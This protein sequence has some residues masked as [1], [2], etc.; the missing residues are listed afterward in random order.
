VVIPETRDPDQGTGALTAEQATAEGSR[1]A[2]RAL[3]P[4]APEP[5]PRT[6]VRRGV[7]AAVQVAAVGV[8]AWVLLLR[9]PGRPA[10][11]TIFGDD[12]FW[13]LPQAI[14]HPWHWGAYGGYVQAVPRLIAQVVSYLPLADAA[15]AFALAGAVVAAGGALFIFHASAGHIQSV[16]LRALLAVALVL[17]PIAPMELIG[18][19][20]ETSWYLLPVLFWAVLWRP[21]TRPAMGVAAAVGFLAMASNILAVLLAPLLVARLYALR[22]PR[23]HAVT[24]G[25]LAGCLVQAT[26]VIPLLLHSQSR[27]DHTLTPPG[28]VLAFYGHAVLA[29]SLGWHTS[30]WLRSLAGADGAAAIAAALLAASLGLI[31]ITQPGARLFVVTAVAVGFIFSVVAVTINPAPAIDLMLPTQADGT[32]YTVMADF[33]IVSALIVGADHA[34]RSRARDRRR[35]RA[36]LKS[37]T[38]VIALVVFLAATWAVDFRYTGLRTTSAWTWAPIAAKWERDCAHSRTGEIHETIYMR[39]WTLP[40]RNITR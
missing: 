34:L 11:R 4:L 22:R 10:W 40:C 33:L 19:G 15:L 30:W 38:A 13:F 9:V 23:E 29:P 28:Q 36:G 25:W 32:R 26:I 5:A 20:V 2:L 7:T 12:Y 35:Q 3:F 6:W 31:L 39:P 1:G 18:S 14:Q 21:R 16:Q 27:L 17:L 37:V 24:A 8:G